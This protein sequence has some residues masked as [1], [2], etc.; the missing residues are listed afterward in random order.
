MA[1]LFPSVTNILSIVGGLCV[2]SV[3]FVLPTLAYIKIK[4]KPG[5][6]YFCGGIKFPIIIIYSVLSLIGYTSV[7]L[8]VKKMIVNLIQ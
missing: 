5:E 6:S 1:V 8:T 3:S 7:F 4:T 2:V